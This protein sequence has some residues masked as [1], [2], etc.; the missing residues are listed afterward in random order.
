MTQNSSAEYHHTV[1]DY[2]NGL[3]KITFVFYRLIN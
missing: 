3:D 2:K 1:G